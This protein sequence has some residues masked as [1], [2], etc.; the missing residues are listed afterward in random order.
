ME[1]KK[2]CYVCK[3]PIIG[4][5]DS[6]ICLGIETGE[7]VSKHCKYLLFDKHIKCSPSRSQHI[8]HKDF[9]SVVDD[10][11]QFDKRLQD[12]EKRNKLEEKYTQAWVRLQKKHNP[13]FNDKKL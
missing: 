11:E 6:Q 5:W 12:D 10:R 7:L 8:V 3:E 2:N 4:E 9:P 13:K 1:N